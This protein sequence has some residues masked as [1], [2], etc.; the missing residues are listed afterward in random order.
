MTPKTEGEMLAV[1][2]RVLREDGGAAAAAYLRALQVQG[3]IAQDGW[4]LGAGRLRRRFVFS[5]KAAPR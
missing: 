2:R 1:A 4:E 5:R 3:V